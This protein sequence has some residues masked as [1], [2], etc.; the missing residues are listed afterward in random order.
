M[1][2]TPS[3]WVAACAIAASSQSFHEPQAN[4]IPSMMNSHISIYFRA[5]VTVFQDAKKPKLLQATGVHCTVG[6]LYEL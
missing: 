3:A 5:C 6:Q 1:L 2:R 4:G